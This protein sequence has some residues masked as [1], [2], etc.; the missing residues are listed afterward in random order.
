MFLLFE[1]FIILILYSIINPTC[2]SQLCLV[3]ECEENSEGYISYDQRELRSFSFHFYQ[4]SLF[5]NF[6]NVI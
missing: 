3:N 2:M 6:K 5:Y 4:E 1:K